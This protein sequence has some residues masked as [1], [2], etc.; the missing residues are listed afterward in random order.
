MNFSKEEL[1]QIYDH[2]V[3]RLFKEGLIIN[4]KPYSDAISRTELPLRTPE[5][6]KEVV[7]LRGAFASPPERPFIP[8]NQDAGSHI[9]D[10]ILK[11]GPGYGGKDH[12]PTETKL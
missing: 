11:M 1:D 7:N 4:S 3:E 8:P 6:S 12:K 2:I 9:P 10:A 5:I